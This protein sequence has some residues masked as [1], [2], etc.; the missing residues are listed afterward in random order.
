MSLYVVREE[1]VD[2]LW[3]LLAPFLESSLYV[4]NEFTIDDLYKEVK[5]KLGLLWM[6]F[7]D[8]GGVYGAAITEIIQY[9]KKKVF[10]IKYLGTKPGAMAPMIDT[11]MDV[12]RKLAVDTGCDVVQLHGRKGWVNVLK[13]YGYEPIKY[14]CELDLK[15]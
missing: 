3:P 6:G 4:G 5:N 10:L 7:S 11:A 2:E 13:P 15:G 12:F 8:E 9:P 1:Q 14:V